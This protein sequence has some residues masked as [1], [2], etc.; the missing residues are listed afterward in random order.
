MADSSYDYKSGLAAVVAIGSTTY[1]KARSIQLP[2]ET[3]AV[4]TVEHLGGI[5]N[6]AEPVTDFG[7]IVVEIPEDGQDS[8]NGT[9][10][11]VV[12]TLTSLT[13]KLTATNAYCISDSRA[14]VQ[15]GGMFRRVTFKC[16]TAGVWAAS[17]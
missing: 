1:P 2:E 11:T 8:L 15:R 4:T 9:T 14:N 17:T 10:A 16:M 12:V 5:T 7:Q 13:R 3:A 6:I